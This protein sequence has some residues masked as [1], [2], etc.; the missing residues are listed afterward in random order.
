M[1]KNNVQNIH[2]QPA[3]KLTNDATDESLLWRL[4]DP[5]WTTALPSKQ[6]KYLIT[7][8]RAWSIVMEHAKNYE[9][10]CKIIWNI[11]TKRVA[12]FSG[13]CN[14]RFLSTKVLQ[15]SVAMHANYD[16]LFIDSFTANLQQSVMVKEFWKSVSISQSYRQKYSGTFF[17][18][19]RCIYIWRWWW[20]C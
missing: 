17:F 8:L 5:G 16:R 12:P 20:W 6:E 11:R 10:R 19:T 14:L 13:Q 1:T 18:R 4:L 9:I 15:G 3:H 2:R 7:H